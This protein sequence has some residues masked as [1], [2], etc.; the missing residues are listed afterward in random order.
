MRKF[1]WIALGLVVLAGLIAGMIYR[2]R[3]AK[4]AIDVANVEKD[5][6][7]HNP[8]EP[9][10]PRSNRTSTNEEFSTPSWSNQRERPSSVAQRWPRSAGHHAHG[11]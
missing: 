3:G 4:A 7:D 2:A 5:I 9:Q 6:R 10:E 11:W 1:F 8:W